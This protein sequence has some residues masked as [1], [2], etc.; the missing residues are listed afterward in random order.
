MIRTDNI[1]N[2]KEAGGPALL[3]DGRKN[4]Q[5]GRRYPPAIGC[6]NFNV[7]GASKGKPG[8]QELERERERERE[9][10]GT[11]CSF[12]CLMGIKESNGAAMCGRHWEF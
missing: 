8:Q 1:R 3:S 5:P 7:D 2:W 6:V 9:G 11:F 4:P 12:S 10:G